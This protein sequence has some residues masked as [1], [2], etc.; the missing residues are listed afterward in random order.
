MFVKVKYYNYLLLTIFLFLTTSGCSFFRWFKKVPPLPPIVS[1]EIIP[2]VK[3]VKISANSMIEVINPSTDEIL[4]RFQAK[5]KI[6]VSLRN[7]NLILNGIDYSSK[8]LV[9][10]APETAFIF[11]NSAKYRGKLIFKSRSIS[12]LQVINKLDVEKYLYGVVPRE[13]SSSWP[14]EA[15]KAQA[16]AARTYA[17]YQILHKKYGGY[18]L[19]STV[20]S[21]VY[22]GASAETERTNKAI[23]DTRDLVMSY[24]H[25]LVAAYF[26]STCGGRTE[27]DKYLW[28]GDDLPYLK[29]K[30]DKYCKASPHYNWTSSIGRKE[31]KRRLKEAGYKVGKIYW[32][33]TK[34]TKTKR[35]KYI[36]IKS[37]KGKIIL[38]DREFRK[39]WGEKLILSR[40]YK[41]KNHFS[42][43]SIIGHGWGHGVG[44][45]QW[46]ARGM[47]ESGKNYKQIL[48][49]YYGGTIF[50]RVKIKPYRKIKE[51]KVFMGKRK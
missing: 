24:K 8:E 40:M 26:H 10:N 39:I 36:K 35:V 11:V 23:D 31:L 22:G 5:E 33:K 4:H 38:T 44:M 51:I 3:S 37:T 19:K 6:N 20:E 16:I 47:A 15:L 7:G 45:C 41:T 43:I 2:S 1:V 46:G 9:L 21:Q 27:D 34:K 30:R 14:R 42:G 29:S 48:H 49:H 32:L 25:E 18:D 28:K 13:M 17:I 12:R 50:D